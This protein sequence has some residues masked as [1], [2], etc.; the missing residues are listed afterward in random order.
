M[1]VEDRGVYEVPGFHV[2]T[3][4]NQD[5]EAELVHECSKDNPDVGCQMSDKLQKMM[6]AG[7]FRL[8]T[9]DL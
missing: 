8:L 6:I 5:V 3:A 9:T 7:H 2:S 1:G 4:G